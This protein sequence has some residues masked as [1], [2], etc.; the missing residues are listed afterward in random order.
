[1]EI[2]IPLPQYNS[3]ANTAQGLIGYLKQLELAVHHAQKAVESAEKEGLEISEDSFICFEHP[4]I[5]KYIVDSDDNEELTE[6][7]D[8]FTSNFYNELQSIELKIVIE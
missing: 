3:S 4:A 5:N 2:I 7:M 1:M 8:D 6:F